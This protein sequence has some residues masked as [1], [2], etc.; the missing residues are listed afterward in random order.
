MATVNYGVQTQDGNFN[1]SACP[2]ILITT[3]SD[4]SSI[5]SITIWVKN[6]NFGTTNI[7]GVVHLTSN[8]SETGRTS[9][10][11]TTHQTGEWVTCSFSSALTVSANTSYHIG[12]VGD[13][14]Y[15]WGRLGSDNN[16]FGYYTSSGYSYASA[17]T[18]GAWTQTA[19]RCF[20]IYITY[21]QS[22]GG[23]GAAVAKV[24]GIA[25]A[26]IAKYAGIAKASV[27]KVGGLTIQ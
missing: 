20:D 3:P 13:S 26:S 5:D 22:G 27:K 12:V 2:S 11:A 10:S 7:K 17:G 8:G 15:S 19:G 4:C 6:N 25:I 24:S 16:G 18:A 21:T 9:S 1:A 23:G 14:Q